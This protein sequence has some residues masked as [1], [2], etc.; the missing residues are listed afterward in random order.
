MPTSEQKDY[1]KENYL[2]KTHAEIAKDLGLSPVTVRVYCSKQ[3]LKKA[4]KF[5]DSKVSFILN[6]ANRMSLKALAAATSSNVVTICRI[7]KRAGIDK[8]RICKPKTSVQ[9]Q[10][11][12]QQLCWTCAR[13]A[14]TPEKGED[15]KLYFICSWANKLKP[16]RGWTVTE[17]CGKKYIT[18]CPLYVADPPRK[19]K[20]Y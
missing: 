4:G 8:R 3:G 5:N 16:V 13:A 1:I 15:G 10:K 20:D 19:R 9:P 11:W 17:L 12:T 2:Y 14:N 7:I 6:N 18:D